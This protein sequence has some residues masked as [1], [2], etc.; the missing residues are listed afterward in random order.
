MQFL[1]ALV[2]SIQSEAVA[3]VEGWGLRGLV[4]IHNI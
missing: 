3:T 4:H 2:R 1:Q